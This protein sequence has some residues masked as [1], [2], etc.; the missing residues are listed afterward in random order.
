MKTNLNKNK[1]IS[2]NNNDKDKSNF[3]FKEFY[4]GKYWWLINIYKFKAGP[5]FFKNGLSV[6]SRND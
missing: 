2:N 1:E 5:S 6:N 4:T 3:C